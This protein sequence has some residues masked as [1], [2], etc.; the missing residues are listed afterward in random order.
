[1]Q[2]ELHDVD[3]GNKVSLWFGIEEP[4]E[5]VFLKEKSFTC[6]YTE[7]NTAFLIEP[8]TFDHWTYL[9]SL[10]HTYERK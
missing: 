7:K 4:V 6:L 9:A 2:V 10:L 3:N 5:R 1:M 8:E